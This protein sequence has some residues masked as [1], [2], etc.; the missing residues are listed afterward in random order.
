MMLLKIIPPSSPGDP[1]KEREGEEK[2]FLQAVI[3][4]VLFLLFTLLL[5]PPVTQAL[6][7]PTASLAYEM[8]PRRSQT[9]EKMKEEKKSCFSVCLLRRKNLRDVQKREWGGET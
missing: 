8:P 6:K 7:N 9:G 4:V 5:S 3:F 2:D 1:N